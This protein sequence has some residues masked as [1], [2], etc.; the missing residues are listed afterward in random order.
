MMHVALPFTMLSIQNVSKRFSGVYALKDLNLEIEEGESFG[1]IGPNG[2]GKTTLIRIISG[3]IKPDSGEVSV[4]GYDLDEDPI[5][6]KTLIGVVS[7]NLFLYPDLTARE[8]LLFY[9]KLY[10]L[11]DVE[12]RVEELLTQVGLILR[13][14]ELVGRFSRGMSQRLSLARALIH[15]PP[16]LILDEPTTGLDISG[17]R[18]FYGWVKAFKEKGKTLLITSHDM[19]EIRTL[20]TSVGVLIEGQLI[21]KTTEIGDDLEERFIDLTTRGVR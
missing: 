18:D 3:L 5:K 15:D 16:I 9:S 8:N 21:E 11:T 10:N 7:H 20:S 4:S 14:D 13:E 19:E 2:A 12:S 6:V 1:L 17:K